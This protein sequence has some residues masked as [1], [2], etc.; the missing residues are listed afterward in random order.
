MNKTNIEEAENEK[1]KIIGRQSLANFW[2][3]T[4]KHRKHKNQHTENEIFGR[5]GTRV[6]HEPHVIK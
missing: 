6:W 5:V 2:G 4:P 1:Y 3:T